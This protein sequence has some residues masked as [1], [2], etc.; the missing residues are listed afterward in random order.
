MLLLGS[1]EFVV[2]TSKSFLSSSHFE[3]LVICQFR[4]FVTSFLR[5]V[6]VVVNALDFG[7]VVLALSLLCG[8]TI[9]ESVNF[10][11]VLGFLLSELGKLIL[12][13]VSILSQAVSLISL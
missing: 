7:V 9:S 3:F 2:G 12:E 13:V 5:L 8:D 1:R 10:V 11:L 4:K 6:E